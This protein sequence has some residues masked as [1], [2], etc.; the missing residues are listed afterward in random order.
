MMAE[1]V[2]RVTHTHTHT[3]TNTLVNKENCTKNS[4]VVLANKKIDNNIDSFIKCA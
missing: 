2:A 1:T 3:H 4:V